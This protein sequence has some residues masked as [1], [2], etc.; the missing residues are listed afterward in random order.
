MALSTS[1]DHYWSQGS[2]VLIAALHS[3]PQGLTTTEAEQRLEQVGPNLVKAKRQATV[4][5]LFL[6]QFKSPIILMLLFATGVSAVLGEWVDAAIVLAIILGSAVLS[7]VPL[8]L[9]ML[10][11]LLLITALYVTT[12]EVTKGIFFR[13]V[14]Q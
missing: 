4:L 7:F 11:I 14:H 12:S 3:S 13:R 6:S 10:L 8:P 2:G 9:P 1:V 5:E